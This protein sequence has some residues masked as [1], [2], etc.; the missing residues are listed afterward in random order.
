MEDGFEDFSDVHERARAFRTLLTTY[1][2]WGVSN[3]HLPEISAHLEGLTYA[4]VRGDTVRRYNSL[5]GIDLHP[6]D[7]VY[8][9][10]IV[11]IK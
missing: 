11:R 10:D 8:R 7:E 9:V 4:V 1:P 3:F 2:S 5:E 6:E